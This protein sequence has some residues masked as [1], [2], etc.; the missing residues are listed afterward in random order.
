MRWARGASMNTSFTSNE[1]HYNRQIG[2]WQAGANGPNP[3]ASFLL[4]ATGWSRRAREGTRQPAPPPDTAPGAAAERG[5]DH[6]GGA[7]QR[8]QEDRAGH[9]TGGGR[10]CG[11]QGGSRVSDREDQPAG[12]AWATRASRTRAAISPARRSAVRLTRSRRRPA[13]VT[14]RP[15]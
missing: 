7:R 14:S 6:A 3:A 13:G 2:H 8:R 9:G 11:G 12:R 4:S 1:G 15:G 10:P 5:A